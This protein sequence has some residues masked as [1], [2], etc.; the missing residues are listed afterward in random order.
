[1]FRKEL[2][3]MLLEK[4]MTV[5]EISRSVGQKT[6]TTVDDLTHLFKSLKHQEFE[7]VIEPA[8]CK[9]CA[10]EFDRQKLARPAKCPACKGTWITEPII[11]V[12]AR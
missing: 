7:A 2:L 10:F 8:V 12:V 11:K 5:K 3:A 1:M 9:K 4:P 6:T